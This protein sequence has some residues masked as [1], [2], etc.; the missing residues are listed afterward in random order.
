MCVPCL[1][2][3]LPFVSGYVS[4]PECVPSSLSSITLFLSE[5]IMGI[6]LYLKNCIGYFSTMVFL[7][8]NPI[9]A[10]NQ[11]GLFPDAFPGDCIPPHALSLETYSSNTHH[12]LFELM[13]WSKSNP[14]ELLDNSLSNDHVSPQSLL[15]ST[16]LRKYLY[17]C[18]LWK[19][20]LPDGGSRV[21][22]YWDSHPQDVQGIRYC[23]V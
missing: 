13:V 6:I 16:V 9:H 1:A 7:V 19:P 23:E 20:K 11:S 2:Y 21:S 18:R 22:M 15:P 3:H 8:M 14:L 5:D 12:N 4:F 10:A 17:S